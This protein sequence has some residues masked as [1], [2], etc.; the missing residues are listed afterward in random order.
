MLKL[1][2]GGPSTSVLG[3]ALSVTW[4]PAGEAL[5]GF[6]LGPSA[7]VFRIARDGVPAGVLVPSVELGHAWV[8]GSG[9]Y[10]SLSGGA[11]YGLV[12]AGKLTDGDAQLGFFPRA[13][14]R[15]GYVW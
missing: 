9:F 14:L 5:R 12:F 2:G 4:F 10:C 13:S 6:F 8:W 3:T 11:Q 7:D 15:I 1:L